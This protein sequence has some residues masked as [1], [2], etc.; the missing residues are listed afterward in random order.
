VLTIRTIICFQVTVQD[1][2]PA[3]GIPTHHHAYLF[4]KFGCKRVR[5]SFNKILSLEHVVDSVDLLYEINEFYIYTTMH[6]VASSP[7]IP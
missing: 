5:V 7:L 2:P 4:F 3:K 6:E 1:K